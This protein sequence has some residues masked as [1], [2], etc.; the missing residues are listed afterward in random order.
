M[1]DERRA[2]AQCEILAKHRGFGLE[3]RWPAQGLAICARG[4]LT[5]S[6]SAG[7]SHPAHLS[8]ATVTSTAALLWVAVP[9][10]RGHGDELWPAHGEE[11]P[12]RIQVLRLLRQLLGESI[13]DRVGGNE[14]G[15]EAFR[16]GRHARVVFLA[17]T[18]KHGWTPRDR[19]RSRGQPSPH[20]RF[21]R[22]TA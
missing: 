13:P 16:P 12:E 17:G 5:A 11:L 22:A 14:P 19:G 18:A 6:A 2:L 20:H 3:H 15:E 7:P 8:S 21:G 10:V 4:I 1:T 9:V